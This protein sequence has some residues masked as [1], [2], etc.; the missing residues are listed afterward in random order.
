MSGFSSRTWLASTVALLLAGFSFPRV[1]R[2][3]AHDHKTQNQSQDDHMVDMADHAMGNMGMDSLMSL[4]MQMTPR[5]LAT[6]DDSTRALAIVAELRH[7]IAK[8][9]DV[10]VAE[11]DGFQMFMPNVKNQRVYHFTNY[12]NAFKAAFSFD[13]DQPTSLLYKR[14]ADG[15][16]MLVGAMYTMP[17][18]AGLDQLD[19]RVPLGI[20]QWH[21]HVNWC[22]PKAGESSRW[23]ERK[24]GRPVFGP[25]SPIASQAACDAVGGDFHPSLFGWMIHANVFEGEDLGHIFG[26]DHNHG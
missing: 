4:H 7:A 16:M 22:L 2:G 25:E 3:Q 19:E 8:Y 21:K 1:A 10:A 20:A 11:H 26:D 12:R 23:V 9:K 18:R 14:G 5:R 15:Q 17:K 6:H 13:P 24:D